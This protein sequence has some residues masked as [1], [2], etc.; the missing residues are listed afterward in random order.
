[1]LLAAHFFLVTAHP[2]LST[3]MKQHPTWK[4]EQQG[5]TAT[6]LAACSDSPRTLKPPLAALLLFQGLLLCFLFCFLFRLFFVL[7]FGHTCSFITTWVSSSVSTLFSIKYRGVCTLGTVLCLP[8]G[9]SRSRSQL[10]AGPKPPNLRAPGLS[11][12]TRSEHH[13]TV[14]Q[15]HWPAPTQ[16][17]WTSTADVTVSCFQLSITLEGFS[18]SLVASFSFL[19]ARRP[20]EYLPQECL[21]FLCSLFSSL[22]LHFAF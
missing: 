4:W 15:R 5:D 21:F 16:R 22:F 19:P 17:S 12:A 14:S 13:A 20:P 1:M 18:R 11:T 2:S 6:A 3:E 8:Q 9:C 7:F 10:H